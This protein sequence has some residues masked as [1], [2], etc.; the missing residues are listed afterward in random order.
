MKLMHGHH[1]QLAMP[2]YGEAMA[3][4]CERTGQREWP[5]GRLGRARCWAVAGRGGVTALTGCAPFAI[6]DSRQL[7]F[8]LA[9]LAEHVHLQ[10][11]GHVCAGQRR[12]LHH[13]GVRARRK[14]TCLHLGERVGN[15]LPSVAVKQTGN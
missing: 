1:D 7:A 5:A 15:I 9:L 6:V 8:V 12:P 4:R 2:R 13:A 3:R 10:V 14:W 11:A